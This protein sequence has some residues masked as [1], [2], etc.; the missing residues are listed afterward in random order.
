LIWALIWLSTSHRREW[1][2]LNIGFQVR[3]QL[4]SLRLRADVNPAAKE[5]D[6]R[7]NQAEGFALPQP[8]ARTKSHSNPVSGRNSKHSLNRKW[9]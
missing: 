7:D 3:R 5:I 2:G 4:S 8:K 1:C 6:A 9:F